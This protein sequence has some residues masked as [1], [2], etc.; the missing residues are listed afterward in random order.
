MSR[1]HLVQACPDTMDFDIESCCPTLL[2]QI[3]SRLTVRYSGWYE[4]EIATLRAIVEDRP[5]DF[6]AKSWAWSP[7]WGRQ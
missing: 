3:V 6:A 5:I 1:K 7:P 2:L 4:T